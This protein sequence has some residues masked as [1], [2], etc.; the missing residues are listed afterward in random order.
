MPITP[1]FTWEQDDTTLAL[2]IQIPGGRVKHA[3]VYGMSAR[4]VLWLATR[5]ARGLT[6]KQ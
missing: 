1:R 2:E 5:E 6:I 3:D 4:G